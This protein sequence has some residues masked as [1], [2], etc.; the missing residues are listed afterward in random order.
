[1]EN[2]IYVHSLETFSKADTGQL[3]KEQHEKEQARVAEETKRAARKAASDLRVARKAAEKKREKDARIV[4]IASCSAINILTRPQKPS[5]ASTALRTLASKPEA[6]QQS[7]D[8][9][10]TK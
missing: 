4:R 5:K 3:E 10:E 6:E 7:S 2:L 9:D 8:H 1:V